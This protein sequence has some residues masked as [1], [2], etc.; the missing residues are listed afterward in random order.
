MLPKN[1]IVPQ[2]N[3]FWDKSNGGRRKR[4]KNVVYRGHYVLPAMPSA[5]HALLSDQNLPSK[6]KSLIK[7]KPDNKLSIHM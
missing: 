4:E 3:P 5:A 2:Y 1:Y 6:V 7:S